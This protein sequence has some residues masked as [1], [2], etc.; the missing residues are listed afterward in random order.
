MYFHAIF[1]GIWLVKPQAI[2][3]GFDRTSEVLRVTFKL[4][5]T[6]N[7]LSPA[8]RNRLSS[9]DSRFYGI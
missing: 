5:L 7:V 9:L 6:I 3:K 8:N 2:R 4:Y 1:D